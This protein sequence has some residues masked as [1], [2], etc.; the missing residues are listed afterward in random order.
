MTTILCRNLEISSQ[1]GKKT[2]RKIFQHF[3][4]AN[5]LMFI[6]LISYHKVYLVQF[7][8]NLH[9]RVFVALAEVACAIQAF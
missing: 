6:L 9:F 2:L 7:G 5:V 4:H 8:I 1:M 3:L